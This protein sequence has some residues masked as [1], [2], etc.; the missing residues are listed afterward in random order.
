MEETS[1]VA[2]AESRLPQG[3]AASAVEE[4]TVEEAEEP[5]PDEVES[6]QETIQE[7]TI[8]A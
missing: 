2:E 7:N 6:E 5:I 3:E 4:R 1:E 8:V